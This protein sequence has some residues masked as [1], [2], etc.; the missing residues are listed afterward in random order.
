MI[1]PGLFGELGR[2]WEKVGRVE[3]S[4]KGGAYDNELSR[5]RYDVTLRLGE[6][7]AVVA[8]QR[9]LSWEASGAW[10]ETLEEALR[11]QPGVSVGVRG[12]RDRR[13]A[14]AVEAVRLLHDPGCVLA[15]AE[16][17]EAVSSGV[18]GE[19]PDAVVGLARGLG[20][21]FCWQ[22]FGADGVYDGVF[23]PCWQP[24]PGVAPQPLTDCHRY[25][26]APSRVLE[27]AEL[28]RVLRTTYAVF[29][30]LHGARG[31]RS[32]AFLAAH[33]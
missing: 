26:N 12:I 23:N 33:P 24:L 7:A 22:G 18:S 8:P 4:L 17:L 9:W 27:D 6:K 5:F 20:V 30:R 13:V 25:G 19:H 31:H 3:T 1:D 32:A 10:R 15:D 16:E 11:R 14:G 28:G 29:T 21:G 2:R